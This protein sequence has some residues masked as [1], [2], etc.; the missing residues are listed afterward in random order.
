M[1]ASLPHFAILSTLLLA[2]W[3]TSV[4][5]AAG[6]PHIVLIISDDQGWTDYGF[7]GHEVIETPHL[8]RLAR[9]STVFRR[10]YVPTAL[11]RPSLMTL[12]TGLYA[13]QH[14]VTGN[15]PS[16]KYAA[17][18]SPLMSRRRGELI[19]RIDQQA[20]L[21]AILGDLGYLSHQSGKYW[22]GHY[23]RA[24]FTH[25]MTAG[26]PSPG[27]RHGDAG[28][29]IGRKGLQPIAE[30]ID[31]ALAQQQPFLLWYAPFLP[32]TPHDPPERLLS[33][34]QSPDRSL[35]MARY[36]A[37]CEWFDE[38]CGELLNLLDRRGLTDNT[39]VVYVT[40]NGWIQDPDGQR[41]APRSKQTPYEGGVRTPILFRWPGNIPAVERDELVSSI[42]I[43]P[44]LLAAAGAQVPGELPGLNLIPHLTAPQPI[45]R[46]RI[47]GETFAH[48][49]ADLNAPE[50][51]L[52]YRWCIE[53]RWK[54]I[55]TYDGE[56]YRNDQVHDRKDRRPQLYD[57]SNDPHERHN[58]AAEYPDV[59]ARLATAIDAWY[60]VTTARTVKSY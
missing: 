46:Q 28:L 38:T 10:G 12:L 37:M 13:Y 25:G 27:G 6:T 41:F 20:T 22:E 26:F 42:D 52:L 49:I 34:Y 32:H 3:E 54:L 29:T 36:Y 48:D 9:E 18:D 30:F 51:S 21:P 57:L 58:R 45:E 15:D 5:A 16:P 53:D 2:G 8:D 60:P 14:G 17:Q 47:F 7:M 19:A 23:S 40:D 50:A 56:A 4:L 1:F 35:P 31:L 44:T 43:M 39:L 59:V 11:C 24:G 33:K 55:L